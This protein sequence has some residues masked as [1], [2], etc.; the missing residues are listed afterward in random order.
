MRRL[1]VVLLLAACH[2]E[3]TAAERVAEGDRELAAGSASSIGLAV[4][5]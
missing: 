1:L 3:P 5:S 2:R 4:A